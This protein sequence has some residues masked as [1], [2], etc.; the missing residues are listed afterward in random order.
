MPLPWQLL[1]V[2]ELKGKYSR[3]LNNTG[4]NPHTTYSPPSVSVVPQHPGI[5]PTRDYILVL[6]VEKMHVQVDLCGS[7]PRC[8]GVSCTSFMC[9][10]SC[11]FQ[12]NILCYPLLFLK[13]ESSATTETFFLYTDPL[14]HPEAEYPTLLPPPHYLCFLRQWFSALSVDW[15]NLESFTNTDMN[16]PPQLLV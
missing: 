14:F 12:H 1:V 13:S 3:P 15:T 5:Q 6:T 16:P 10:R 11:S 8:S 2:T 7:N 9:M 4:V